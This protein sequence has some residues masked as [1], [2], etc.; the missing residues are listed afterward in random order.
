MQIVH[1]ISVVIVS[2]IVT[3]LFY[4]VSGSISDQ[5]KTVQ[6]EGL[7]TAAQL[8]CVSMVENMTQSLDVIET[9]LPIGMVVAVIGIVT[10]GLFRSD[11][12]SIDGGEEDEDEFMDGKIEEPRTF[13]RALSPEEVAG[14]YE[15][16]PKGRSKAPY[17]VAGCVAAGIIAMSLLPIREMEGPLKLA[18]ALGVW[19]PAV[20][21]LAH[22]W[23]RRRA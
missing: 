16:K 3:V 5:I 8:N 10:M 4:T 12:L 14:L 20:I 15:A 23:R 11:V 13:D 22:Y 21:A 2:I 19:A 9:L 18:A 1:V 7:D 17:V 6:C